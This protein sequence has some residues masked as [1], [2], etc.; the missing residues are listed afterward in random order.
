MQLLILGAHRREE[1]RC[2]VHCVPVHHQA[3]ARQQIVLGVRRELGGV[4]AV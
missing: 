1:A 2:S 4:R 3:A